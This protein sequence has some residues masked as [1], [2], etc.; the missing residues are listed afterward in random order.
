[1]DERCGD[2]RRQS[3]AHCRQRI[4]EKQCIRNM[5]AVVAREPNL[6]HAV[7]EANDADIRYRLAHIV[8]DALRRQ[9]KAAFGGTIGEVGEDVLA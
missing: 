2:R 9:G 6:E 7:V 8:D 1:M 5:G 4:V 3:S